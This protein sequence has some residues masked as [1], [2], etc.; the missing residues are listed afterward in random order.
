MTAVEILQHL[1]IPYRHQGE[2]ENTSRGW[3]NTNCPVCSP[4]SG[5]FRCGIHIATLRANCWVCG[6]L[7][8]AEVLVE[9]SGRPLG[10]VLKL[11]GN[12]DDLPLPRDEKKTGTYTPPPGVGPLLPAH[13]KYLEGR[14]FDP[15][16]LT[17]L[18]NLGGIGMEGRYKW[19]I[20]IPVLLGG[21]RVSWTTRRV[22]EG[23]SRRY[24][25]APPEYEER[26]I[27]D[28]LYG[29]DR[30]R[31]AAV[32]VEGPADAWAI[33]PGAVATFGLSVTTPQLALLASLP[34][35]VICMDNE[36]RARRKSLELADALEALPGTTH[37]VTLSGK[38]AAE[39]PR[40]EIR[41]LRSRFLE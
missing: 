28:C 38:D 20:F 22:G 30:V 37:V 14:G 17:R 35:R 3:V 11:L 34:V 5:R 27:H 21:K 6:R 9:A 31:H 19:R 23:Q 18:W 32:V 33:G 7:N 4:D 8:T 13:R 24:L 15:D 10:E 25:A 1:G 29:W 2:H 36:P 26:P 40:E 12:R 39:S 16:E 41:E